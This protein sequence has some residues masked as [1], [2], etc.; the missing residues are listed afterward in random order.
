M[1]PVG[2][3]EDKQSAVLDLLII[4]KLYLKMRQADVLRILAF[5]VTSKTQPIFWI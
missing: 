2:F 5:K 1:G 3:A 4:M